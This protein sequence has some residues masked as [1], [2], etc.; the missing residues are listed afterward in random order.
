M[1][2]YSVCRD[3]RE[4]RGFGWW[5]EENLQCDGTI[6]KTMRTGDY[7]IDGMEDTLVI[8]RKG[9]LSEFAAN[10][11]D[12]R[13]EREMERMS[14][15]DQSIVMLE[16]EY[17]DFE[18]WPKSAGLTNNQIAQVKTSAKFLRKKVHE[19][20]ERYGVRFIFAGS[21]GQEIAN[22]IFLEVVNGKKLQ[23]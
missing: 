12:K 22:D 2:K 18:N 5:F 21:D 3:S 10:L 6:I 23:D 19:F 17:E 9:C 16:F 1:N 13:F 14:H 4:K 8:D 11:T 20:C 15:I 7:S